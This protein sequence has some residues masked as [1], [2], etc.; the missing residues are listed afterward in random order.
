MFYHSSKKGI[1]M[2]TRDLKSTWQSYIM[3]QRN[4]VYGS[5]KL[6][7]TLPDPLPCAPHM[8]SLF[9]QVKYPH[10]H[11][12]Q[13][14]T[15]FPVSAFACNAPWV[16]CRSSPPSLVSD[17]CSQYSV[18][19]L[20]LQCPVSLSQTLALCLCDVH[21]ILTYAVHLD[22][23]IEWASLAPCRPPG[24]QVWPQRQ[25]LFTELF[26]DPDCIKVNCWNK[27]KFPYTDFLKDFFFPKY[28]PG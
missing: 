19:L 3:C 26:Q 28:M 8:N 21:S 23:P 18:T 16:G 24:T 20:R 17:C 5:P 11:G 7:F 25:S 13:C 10:C 22:L 4:E 1:C 12:P 14:S 9:N 2:R 27:G 15:L 6:A